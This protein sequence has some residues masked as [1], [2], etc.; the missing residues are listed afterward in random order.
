M[1]WIK[2]L[3]T[4][5][6]STDVALNDPTPLAHQNMMMYMEKIKQTKKQPIQ[7][8]GGLL[9]PKK[10]MQKVDNNM[11]IDEPRLRTASY[12]EQIQ[13]KREEISNG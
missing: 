6:W 12:I 5:R 4:I 1:L 13:A 7:D 3:K 11:R 2:L 8:K 9:G 10:S